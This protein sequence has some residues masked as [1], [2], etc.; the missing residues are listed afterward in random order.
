MYVVPDSSATEIPKLKSESSIAS[1]V[2]RKQFIS[3]ICLPYMQIPTMN[4]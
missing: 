3:L 4:M 1:T 2:N